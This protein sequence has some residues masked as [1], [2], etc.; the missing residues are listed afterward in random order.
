MI[1]CKSINCNDFSMVNNGREIYF[2][3]HSNSKESERLNRYYLESLSE[4]DCINLIYDTLKQLAT[5]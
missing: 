5:K 4:N 2:F 1:F 3:L